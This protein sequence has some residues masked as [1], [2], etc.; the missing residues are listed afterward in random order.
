MTMSNAAA[1]PALSVVLI[2]SDAAA[3]VSWYTKALGASQLWDLDGVAGLHLDGAPFFLHEAVPGK[4]QE[5]SPTD[6]GLTTTRI[7]VFVDAPS[8]LIER[9]AQARATDVETETEHDA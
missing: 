4:N 9:A 8:D 2:V 7:E 5:P 1:R 6:V 3:A